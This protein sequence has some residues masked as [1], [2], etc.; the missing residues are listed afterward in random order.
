MVTKS[1][2]I[3]LVSRQIYQV[4]EIPTKKK[5]I[6]LQLRIYFPKERKY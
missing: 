3:V 1:S 2:S 4:S 5:I 6:L